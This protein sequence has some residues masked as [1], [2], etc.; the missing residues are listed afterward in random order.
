MKDYFLAR[1]DPGNYGWMVCRRGFEYEPVRLLGGWNRP[2]VAL[3]GMSVGDAMELAAQMSWEFRGYPSDAEPVESPD[4]TEEELGRLSAVLESLEER[5]TLLDGSRAGKACVR[6]HR[7]TTC[8]FWHLGDDG[9]CLGEAVCPDWEKAL[10]RSP[11]N[12]PVGSP[13]DAV[14]LF[15][16][17]DWEEN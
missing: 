8:R 14:G 13:D 2:T 10:P 1:Q 16:D 3:T 9:R 17:Y 12:V 11:A 6:R 15:D 5:F 4:L 7:K